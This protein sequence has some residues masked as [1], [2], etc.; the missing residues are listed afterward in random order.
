M[1][2][3]IFFGYPWRD[4]TEQFHAYQLGIKLA[5]SWRLLD[6]KLAASSVPGPGPVTRAQALGNV[7]PNS[8]TNANTIQESYRL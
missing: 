7:L 1:E 8:Q 4:T 3:S 6:T 5:P 2:V